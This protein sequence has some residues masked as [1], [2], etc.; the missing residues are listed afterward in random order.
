MTRYRKQ[1]H[2]QL[3][4]PLGTLVIAGISE[5]SDWHLPRMKAA[6]KRKRIYLDYDDA[7]QLG[8]GLREMIGKR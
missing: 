7:E 5:K 6:K 4:K 2:Q 8:E 1:K 3:I